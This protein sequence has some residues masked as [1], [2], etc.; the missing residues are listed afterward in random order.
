MKQK[1]V[2]QLLEMLYEKYSQDEI[3]DN[4]RL[5]K[6]KANLFEIKLKTTNG[7]K[8]KVENSDEISQYLASL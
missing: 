1:T 2:N 5:R 4:S 7:G 6:I 8:V 3:N